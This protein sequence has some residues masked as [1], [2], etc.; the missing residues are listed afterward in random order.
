MKKRGLSTI[1]AS[2]LVVLLVV[3]VMGVIWF[4]AKNFVTTGTETFDIGTK[5]LQV[6]LELVSVIETS[7]GAYDVTLKRI[8]P[9]DGD[10]GGVKFVLSNGTDYSD[11]LDFGSTIKPLATEKSHVEDTEITNAKNIET[12]VYFLDNSGN[13]QIC[14]QT[15]TFTF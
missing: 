13:E 9:G 5:C 1:V 3:V 7:P 12:T 6:N 2:L 11:V 14:Q 10:I 15:S 4:A 8:P